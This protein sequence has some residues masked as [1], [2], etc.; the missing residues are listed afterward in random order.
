MLAGIDI[1]NIYI[2]TERLILRP[3]R[4]SDLE[5]LYDYACVDGVGEMAGWTHHKDKEES[6]RIL[7]MFIQ[8]KK[9][10]AL[11]L[12]ENGKVIGSLGIEKHNAEEFDD[13]NLQGRELGYVL[14]KEYWGKGLMSEATAAVIRFCFETLHYDFISCSHFKRNPRSQRV[15]EKSG[16]SY[17]KDISYETQYGT[18]EPTR[19]YVQY[20]PSLER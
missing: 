16:F 3:W 5:D 8:G 6:Q 9:T 20:N 19:L 1:T 12:K 14:S 17:L 18:V 11:E 15:I 13:P 10:F 7:D 2:E 4:Q